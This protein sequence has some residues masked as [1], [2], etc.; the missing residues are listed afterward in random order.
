MFSVSGVGPKSALNVLSLADIK[1]IQQAIVLGDEDMLTQVSGI[2]RKTAQ[3]LIL[4]LK[5][6]MNIITVDNSSPTVLSGQ[7]DLEAL[8]ALG[9][10]SQDARRALAKVDPL[11]TDPAQRLKSALQQLR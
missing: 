3:R 5:N 9:Y 6:K 1:Q 2:G 8:L 10:G 7:D 4:E 11:I